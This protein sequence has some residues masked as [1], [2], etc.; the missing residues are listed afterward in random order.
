MHAPL[1]P[2][3]VR[4]W[5]V[6]WRIR[7]TRS[8]YAENPRACGECR[9]DLRDRGSG[10]VQC[11]TCG[12]I[13]LIPDPRPGE[14]LTTTLAPCDDSGRRL[15]KRKRRGI[16]IREGWKAQQDGYVAKVF[17]VI[18]RVGDRYREEVRR[19]GVVVH[20]VDEPLT[21]HRGHGSATAKR[22][23]DL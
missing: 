2:T 20:S 18:D 12:A 10:P 13:L 1:S 3:L 14:L 16:Q 6:P 8:P 7:A 15:P 17:R 11:R 23:R 21:S 9:G 19:E 5:V 4:S 22:A